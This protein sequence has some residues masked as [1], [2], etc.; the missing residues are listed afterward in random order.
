MHALHT[1]SGEHNMGNDDIICKLG[2]L[3]DEQRN[4]CTSPSMNPW[5]LSEFVKS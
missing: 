5:A 2:F 3:Q 4:E 1:H